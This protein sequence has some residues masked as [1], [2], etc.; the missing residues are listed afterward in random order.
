[1][2]YLVI[3]S[4]NGE[5]T[6]IFCDDIDDVNN[7]LSG[8]KNKANVRVLKI[9]EIEVIEQQPFVVGGK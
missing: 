8:V 6:N 2:K 7:A 9:E 1:M 3:K 4:F 5:E